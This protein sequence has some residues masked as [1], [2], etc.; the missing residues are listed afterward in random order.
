MIIC[1]ATCQSLGFTVKL[2]IHTQTLFWR[3][4][5]QCKHSNLLQNISVFAKHM[6]S[7]FQSLF[8]YAVELQGGFLKRRWD[9]PLEIFFFGVSSIYCEMIQNGVFVLQK[10]EVFVKYCLTWPHDM[11]IY[12]YIVDGICLIPCSKMFSSM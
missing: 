1:A 8:G 4:A 12:I 6:S 11:H 2:F 9:K 10:H 3:D 7:P 5:L